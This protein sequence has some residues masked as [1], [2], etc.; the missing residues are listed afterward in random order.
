MD[1]TIFAGQTAL[2]LILLVL[3]LLGGILLIPLGLP[4]LW[5]MLGAA[6]VHSFVVPASGIGIMTLIGCTVLVLIA[7]FMEF[8]LSGSYARKYGGSR[9][10]SWGAILG[11]FLGA[12]MGI[13]V[14]IIGP[15]IGAFIGAFAGAFLGEMTVSRADRGNPGRVAWGA[16][17]GRAVATAMKVAV[18]LIIGVW[19]F[20][21]AMI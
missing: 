1:S 10:A 9:R 14:P 3:A 16:L 12:F 21:S 6:V 11:G 4:G 5:I 18:A 7:E 15:M 8:S 19:I 2:P 13:P 17:V 20:T